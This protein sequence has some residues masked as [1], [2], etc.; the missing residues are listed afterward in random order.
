MTEE[1]DTPKKKYFKDELAAYSKSMKIFR[2]GDFQKA[3]GAIKE[4][5]KE[6]P[7]EMELTDRA[8]IYLNICEGRLN[9]DKIILKTFSDYYQYGVYKMNQ[10][11]FK[12]S[13]KALEKA[14]EKKPKEG[15]VFYL[16][17]NVFCLMEDEKKCL[18][19]LKKAVKMDDFFGLL[20][21]NETNFETFQENKKF[22]LITKAK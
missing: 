8:N 9:K 18:E 19:Y 5:L 4:F 1:K 14:R 3:A 20:A 12:E 21:Q 11:E 15:K 17:A 13:L 16:M 2:K 6:Y 7:S 22:N 10:G